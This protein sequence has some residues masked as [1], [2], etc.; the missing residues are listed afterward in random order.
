MNEHRPI[1]DLLKLMLENALHM[2]TG[3]CSLINDLFMRELISY[4]EAMRLENY[5]YINAP[6]RV[7][8]E[9]RH[10]GPLGPGRLNCY[11]WEEGN[12]E[13]RIQWLKEQIAKLEQDDH[14]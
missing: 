10:G 13:P 4:S 11:W 2:R 3:L 1:K 14:K 12:K 9:A 6:D 7:Q 5:L 8:E